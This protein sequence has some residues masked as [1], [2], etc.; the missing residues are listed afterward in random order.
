HRRWNARLARRDGPLIV[1]DAEFDVEVHHQHLGHIP[2]GTRTTEYYWQDQWFNVFRFLDDGGETRFWYCN[3]NLP[4]AVAVSS[5]S[6]IDL[7]IDV[8]VRPDFSYQILDA[9]EFQSHAQMFNY[10]LNLRESARVALAELISR[11]ESRQF[12]FNE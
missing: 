7:D 8:L 4:P 11:I 5:I 10:P 2:L 1:L 6:Y 3:I 9:D 12:P